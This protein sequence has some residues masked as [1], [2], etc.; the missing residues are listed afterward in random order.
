M[1]K[2]RTLQSLRNT[3]WAPAG[4]ASAEY[5]QLTSSFGGDARQFALDLDSCK[6]QKG[7][8]TED[9]YADKRLV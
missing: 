7:L 5:F 8:A 9:K 1:A 4:V 2:K 3:V 6:I